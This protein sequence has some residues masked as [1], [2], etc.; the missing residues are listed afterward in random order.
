MRYLVV[1]EIKLPFSL[2]QM[3]PRTVKYDDGTKVWEVQASPHN[4]YE[5]ILKR[6]HPSIT[7][8]QAICPISLGEDGVYRRVPDPTHEEIKAW[9]ALL[10]TRFDP[11]I[12]AIASRAYLMTCLMNIGVGYAIKK[13][14]SSTTI[15]AFEETVEI[16]HLSR[17]TTCE[18]MYAGALTFSD[19]LHRQMWFVLHPPTKDTPDKLTLT[20]SFS[21]ETFRKWVV[22]LSTHNYSEYPHHKLMDLVDQL[23]S[24]TIDTNMEGEELLSYTLASWLYVCM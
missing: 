19:D 3:D 14:G 16:P 7:Y 6:C 15:Q 5:I 1:D 4:V 10:A 24:V 22:D 23:K 21:N 17:I 13:L 9:N 12:S 20:R 8:E 18:A 2:K 11:E